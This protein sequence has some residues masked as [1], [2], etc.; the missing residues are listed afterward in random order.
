MTKNLVLKDLPGEV[1][2][3]CQKYLR[4]LHG[5]LGENLH[6][7]YLYGAMTFPDS[8]RIGDIDGHVIVKRP[9]TDPE[10][11]DINRLHEA[12]ACCF[13]SLVGEGLDAPCG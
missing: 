9:F 13:P 4:G 5:T 10:R 1:R 2:S 11:R 6:G 3:F 8:D 7:V 12:L